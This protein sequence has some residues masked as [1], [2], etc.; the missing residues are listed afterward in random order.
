MTATAEKLDSELSAALNKLYRTRK[1]KQ[2][3]EE[4]LRR[5]AKTYQQA[6]NHAL[7]A[8]INASARLLYL[9]KVYKK[10]RLKEYRLVK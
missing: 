4:E 10:V 9:K 3:A 8:Y 6:L 7:S 1:L 2:K 5:V